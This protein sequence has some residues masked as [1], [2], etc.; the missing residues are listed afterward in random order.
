MEA[1]AGQGNFAY[2][3]PEKA[4]YKFGPYLCQVLWAVA[5]PRR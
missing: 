5:S 2:S 3:T 1:A 4:K